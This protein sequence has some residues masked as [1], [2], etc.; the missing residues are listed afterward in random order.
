MRL[1]VLLISLFFYTSHSLYASPIDSLKQLLS[2]TG[3]RKQK[4]ALSLSISKELMKQDIKQAL[5]YAHQAYF[6]AKAEKDPKER[7]NACH[8]LATVF[9]SAG[10]TDKA[11][12][13][14]LESRRAAIESGDKIAILTD[15]LN[16]GIMNIGVEEFEKARVVLM[17]GDSSIHEAYRSIGKVVP[18]VDLVKLYT[19]IALC[20]VNL[21]EMPSGYDYL[22]KATKLID[23]LENPNALYAKILQVR[24]LG[25]MKEKKPDEAIIQFEQAKQLLEKEGE[26]IMLLLIHAFMGD[27][28]ELKGNLSGAIDEYRS[29]YFKSTQLNI[30]IL[31]SRFSESLYKVYQKVPNQDSAFKYLQIFTGISGELKTIKAKEQLTRA[32]LANEFEKREKAL[33]Q[34][35]NSKRKQYTLLIAFV[36]LLAVLL[37]IGVVYYRKKYTVVSINALK[38]RLEAEKSDLEQR[39]L[40]AELSHREEELA[41]LEQQISRNRMLEDLINDLQSDQHQDHDGSNDSMIRSDE[42]S[43]IQKG[44]IW[45][46]FEFRFTNT[47]VGFFEKLMATCP[48]LTHNERRLCAFLSL[49]MTTK[50]ISSITGQSVRAIEVARVRLRKKL[51]LTQSEVSLFEYL[52]KL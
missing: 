17:Q 5:E 30:L 43:L 38:L 40:Q 31:K 27:A 1:T 6:L 3:D 39:R 21:N 10:M 45:E 28:Y 23:S 19:N 16:M 36:L 18:V 11:I 12:E 42:K 9:Y 46:E 25:L 44:K 52:S 8:Q 24:G 4:I 48:D 2:N 32:E 33:N 49:D 50:E 15:N 26:T 47:H 51:N 37:A 7:I 29:G 20:H 22:E 13:W 35:F 14:L 41:A 34:R